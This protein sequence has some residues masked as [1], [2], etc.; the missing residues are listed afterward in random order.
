MT[1][2]LVSSGTAS[3]GVCSCEGRWG[4]RRVVT[5][6][7]EDWI[8][9]YAPQCIDRQKVGAVWCAMRV[10]FEGPAAIYWLREGD[11]AASLGERR[12]LVASELV[13]P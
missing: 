10:S 11:L 6:G 13:G 9:Y 3:L 4:S 5:D 7:S 2:G 1:L 12:W 8:I